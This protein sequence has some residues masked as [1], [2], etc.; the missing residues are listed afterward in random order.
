MIRT[1]HAHLDTWTSAQR[2]AAVREGRKPDRVPFLGFV[3]AYAAWISNVPLDVHYAHPEIAVRNQILTADLHGYDFAPAFGWADW[4]AWEFGGRL[5]YPQSYRESAPYTLESPVATPSDVEKIQ[6]PDV[7]NIGCFPTLMQ[8]NRI[9]RDLGFGA[10]IMGGSVTNVVAAMVG[11][12]NLLRWYHKEKE[13]LHLA[14]DKAAELII[15]GADL[16]IE[17]FGTETS[18]GYGSPLESNNLISPEV[19]ETF[20]WP[21]LKKI[22][23]TMLNR[24]ISRFGVHICGNHRKNLPLWA[25]LPWP[26]RSTISVGAEMDL[27]HVA[28]AFDHRHIVAGNVSTSTL[29]GGT[30]QE[31]LDETRRR[32]EIGKTLPGGF[33]LMPACEMPVLTP[34]VNVHALVAAVRE[35]GR[36]E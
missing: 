14:F 22:H 32:I 31:V 24:G 6:V 34:P 28:E 26:D 23:Q 12:Q 30:Y 15:R 13:A 36:Y 7:R 20:A 2:L 27:A 4:G 1:N 9:C 29:A 35:Y 11:K 19:F 18:F 16:V 25:A 5:Q 21:R 33:I 17:E 8:F 10:K 3:N